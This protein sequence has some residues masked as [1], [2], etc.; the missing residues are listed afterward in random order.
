MRILIYKRTHHGDPDAGGCFGINDCMGK[1]RAHEFDA[2]IGVGG[3]GGEARSYNINGKINWIGIGPQKLDV[4]RKRGPEVTFDHF[5]DYGTRGPDFRVVA[6]LL[7]ERI[8]RD[9]VRVLLL[10]PTSDE[11]R[12]AKRIVSRASRSK[13]SARRSMSASAVAALH[14]CKPRRLTRR[15][16]ER[17]MAGGSDSAC[18][19]GPRP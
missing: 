19:A 7:A 5:L 6:P 9:N 13:A 17:L 15:C 3:I 8:Y 1:V 18:G 4:P 12:E 11:F 16:S 10:S 14:R 2:V